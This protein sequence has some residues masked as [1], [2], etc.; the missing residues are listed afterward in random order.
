MMNIDNM[1]MNL[2][3]QNGGRAKR[4]SSKRQRKRKNK[5]GGSLLADASVPAGLFLLHR[6]LKNKKSVKASKKR[7]PKGRRT[8]RRR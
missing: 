3:N 4:K 2:D 7:R 5:R 8:R 6:Y 1:R